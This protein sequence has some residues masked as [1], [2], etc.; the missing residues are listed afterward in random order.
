MLAYYEEYNVEEPLFPKPVDCAVLYDRNTPSS[1]LFCL[2]YRKHLF[3]PIWETTALGLSH[4]QES[5][6]IVIFF[7]A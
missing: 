2:L 5:T 7:L 4:A 3:I 1:A 6:Y